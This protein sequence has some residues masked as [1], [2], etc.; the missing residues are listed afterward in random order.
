MSDIT[1]TPVP[2]AHHICVR[3]EVYHLPFNL[4]WVGD[5]PRWICGDCLDAIGLERKQ[6]PTLDD[7]LKSLEPRWVPVSEKLPPFAEDGFW[8]GMVARGAIELDANWWDENDFRDDP[9][10]TNWLDFAPPELPGEEVGG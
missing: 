6:R 5:L 9:R 8:F 7:H 3:C 2:A 1:R 4:F 10:I